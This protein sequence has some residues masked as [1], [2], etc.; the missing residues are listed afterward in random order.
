MNGR[1]IPKNQADCDHANTLRDYEAA[2]KAWMN[3]NIFTDAGKLAKQRLDVAR[4][5]YIAAVKAAHPT[6]IVQ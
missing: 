2:H 6:W 4:E 5:N 3:T 1:F